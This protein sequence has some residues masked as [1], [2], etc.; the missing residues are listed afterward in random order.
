MQRNLSISFVF[1]NHHFLNNC[2]K[3]SEQQLT[4]KSQAEAHAEA[5]ANRVKDVPQTTFFCSEQHFFY[6]FI[7]NNSSR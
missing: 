6:F 1:E 4:L 3:M 5:D 7:R 2:T